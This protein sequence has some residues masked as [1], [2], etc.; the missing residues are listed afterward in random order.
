[1]IKNWNQFIRESVT[2]PDSYLD[3]RMQEIKDLL[4]N[5]ENS[6]TLIYEWENKNDH[7]LYVNFSANG[8]N[9]R[10]EFDIDD[11]QVTKIANDVHDFTEEVESMEAGVEMIEKD[12]HSIL[13]ISERFLNEAIVDYK[14][15]D[16]DDLMGEINTYPR[17]HRFQ[18]EDLTRLGAEYNIE[19]VDYDTFYRDLSERDK[20]T[21][22]PRS[23]QFFALVNPVTKRPRVV[24]NLP[25]PFIPKD[26]FD[27]VPLGDILKHEQIHVGQHSRR[28]NIDMSLPDPKNQ[29]QYFSN[30]D[31]VMAFAFSVAKEIVT[32]F[33]TIT[34]PREGIDKLTQNLGRFRLYSDIKR[35]VD[36]DTLKRYNKYIY[37]Y[38][39]DLLKKEE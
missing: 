6:E 19:I 26:F 24:L 36:A 22:P 16:V 35:N 5:N 27:Q 13:G 10:Y 11:M 18:I 3:M 33:P 8:M 23:A 34:T 29:K 25:M 14:S 38:L 39:E 20:V 17:H 15:D 12:I 37:L 21:A 7:E 1:M 2:N 31:E 28:P 32:M 4:D 30:K 9:V